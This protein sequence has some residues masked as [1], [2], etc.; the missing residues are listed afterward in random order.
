M[1][2]FA[3]KVFLFDLGIFQDFVEDSLCIFD[4]KLESPLIISIYLRLTLK[5]IH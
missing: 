2:R 5:K 1:S 4:S 3:A